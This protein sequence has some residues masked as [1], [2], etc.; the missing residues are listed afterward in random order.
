MTG[1]RCRPTLRRS[2]AILPLC[3]V[4][5]S[6]HAPRLDAQNPIV[7]PGVYLADPSA[8]V[9]EDG[10]VYVYGSRDED[11]SYYCSWSQDVLSSPDLLRWEVH[12]D[13]FASKGPADQVPYS[14]ALL[15]APDCHYR[16]GTYFLYYCLASG[17]NT[18]GVATSPSPAGPFA[19]G[20]V[21]DLADIE[22]IDPAVF[23]D[24]DG[25]A[26]Y[27]WGQFTAKV[28]KLNTDM[29]TID[30]ATIKDRVLTETEHF[31]HEGGSMVKRN[32][33]YYFVYAHMGRGNRP[34]CLGYATSRSPLGPFTYGGVIVDNDHCD[35]AVWNNHGSLLEFRGRWYVLYHRS[36]HGSRTMRKACIEPIAF[37]GDG[38]IAEVEMTSQG[39]GDPLDARSAIDAARAC[40]LYGDVRI[41]ASGPG[42]EELAGIRQGDCAGYKYV[43]FGAGVGGV[44]VRVA[45]GAEPGR[46]ELALDQM[47][48]APVATIEVP[49]GGDGTAWTELTAAVKEA[50]GV[51]ALWLRFRGRGEDL[52][53]VDAFR[54]GG[55]PAGPS[56]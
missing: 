25:Q 6:L 18:E 24:D 47:W 46:I 33:L 30:P 8:R 54:F 35:P 49:G 5:L 48:S 4:G 38:R 12:R 11:P 13:V 22:E 15:Y 3:A 36:T 53:R 40:L 56:R 31:F 41:Q 34:T 20:R 28:A 17:R 23:V 26:Y 55:G 10:R 27:I 16:N 19:G 42:R 21:I 43:D 7:P 37:D 39:A 51:H 32:G 9:W 1:Q 44:T 50:R 2:L 29:T 52:F 14:D 45:P